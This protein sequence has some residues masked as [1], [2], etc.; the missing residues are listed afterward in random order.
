MSR[1]EKILTNFS[2]K[3]LEGRGLNE[4]CNIEMD[5]EGIGFEDKVW[6][7]RTHVKNLW[8]AFV[9]AVMNFLFPQNFYDF[10]KKLR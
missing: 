5:P 8:R 10:F 4:G 6:F 2:K 7:P 3:T 1:N 9:K